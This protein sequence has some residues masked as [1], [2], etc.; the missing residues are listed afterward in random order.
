MSGWWGSYSYRCQPV[1]YSNN[2]MALRVSFRKIRSQKKKNNVICLS[3]WLERVGGTIFRNSQNF[4]IRYFSLFVRKLVTFRLYTSSITVVCHF[5]FGWVWNLLQVN[6]QFENRNLAKTIDFF[7]LQV[8]IVHFS[9][10]SILLYTLL[11][12]F[13]IWLPRWVLNIKNIFG[14]RNIWPR[15]KWCNSSRFSPINFNCYSPNATI[16]KDLWFGSRCMALC[17]CFYSQIFIKLNIPVVR[18][19]KTKELVW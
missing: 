9:H 4:S 2:S 15:S 17:F 1:D 14:G 12:I 7:C 11:C 19:M 5:R 10:C 16:L 6:L 13:I 18:K 3:R 8:A